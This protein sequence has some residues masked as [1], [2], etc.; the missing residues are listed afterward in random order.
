MV[1]AFPDV[2]SDKIAGQVLLQTFP[3][4]PYGFQ[5]GGEGFEVPYVADYGIGFV[6]F[7]QIGQFYQ[8]GFEFFD[9][10]SVFGRYLNAVAGN[11]AQISFRQYL[12]LRRQSY[13]FY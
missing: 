4:A 13:R 2:L 7:G 6:K 9:V 5:A 11:M 12:T 1:H 10:L 3:N 8:F